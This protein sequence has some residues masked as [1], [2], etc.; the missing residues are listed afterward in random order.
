MPRPRQPDASATAERARAYRERRKAGLVVV[1]IGG[2]RL[3]MHHD[4]ACELFAEAREMQR[5]RALDMS[6]KP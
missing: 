6:P 1:T 5:K 2:E 4:D 3:D